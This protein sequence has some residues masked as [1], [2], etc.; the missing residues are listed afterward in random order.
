M[1]PVY[2]SFPL[3]LNRNGSDVS[4]LTIAGDHFYNGNELEDFPD[5]TNALEWF[6]ED[7]EIKKYKNWEFYEQCVH[8]TKYSALACLWT[9]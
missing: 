7:I 8:T 9:F 3:P 2:W 6:P 4:P 5:K 1:D